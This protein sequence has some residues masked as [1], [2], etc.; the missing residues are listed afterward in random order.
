M[1][2]SSFTLMEPLYKEIYLSIAG[3]ALQ[4]IFQRTE[5]K[6]VREEMMN[7]LINYYRGFIVEKK[8]D[9]VDYR[10]KFLNT[11]MFYSLTKEGVFNFLMVFKRTKQKKILTFYHIGLAQIRMMIENI[12]QELLREKG[13]VLHA[14]ASYIN[15]KAYLFTGRSGAGKSTIMKLLAKKYPPL[16]DDSIILKKEGATFYAYQTPFFEKENWLKRRSLKYEI[17]LLYFLRKA[18]YVNTEKI[19]DHEYVCRRLIKQ[20]FKYQNNSASQTK[21]FFS[22]VSK[23]R[24][25]YFLYFQKDDSVVKYLNNQLT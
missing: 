16:A 15:G 23:F 18:R 21:F 10:I 4:I 17:G 2:D 12:L 24:K 3:Y 20:F 1:N 25:F 8:P 13:F 19:F 22:F 11:S 9:R 6:S 14:S 7:V 5:I